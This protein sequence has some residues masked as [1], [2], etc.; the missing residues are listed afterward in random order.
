MEERKFEVR[1][2]NM[3]KNRGLYITL[4]GVLIVSALAGCGKKDGL[5]PENPTRI[6][7]LTYYNG[8]PQIAFEEQVKLFNETVGAEKGIFVEA[9]SSGDL[10][11]LLNTLDFELS[12]PESERELAD[13]FCC[14]A[15][16]AIDFL[17][18]DQLVD[19]DEYFTEDE[20]AE[21]VDAYIEEGRIGKNDELFLFPM[22]K[23]TEV[24]SV[25]KTDWDL[26]A[27][28]T[29][30]T[31]ESLSTWEGLAETAK[32]YYEWTDAATQEPND[33]K[34]FFGRDAMA[35]YILCGMHQQDADIFQVSDGSTEITV[36]REAMRKVWDNYYVPYISGYY[37][38]YGRY[39]SDDMKTGDI[40]ALVGSS[41]GATFL[42]S[43]VTIG[44]E[45]PYAIEIET[46]EIPNFDGEDPVAVQQGAGMVVSKSDALR[47]EASVTFLKW[48]TDS[49]VNTEFAVASSYLPVKKDANNLDFANQ[50]NESK[51][52]ETNEEIQ[53]TL[54]AS[55]EVCQ[56]SE[57]YTMPS[58]TG[59][60]EC[61]DILGNS[62]QEKMQEDRAGIK[63]LL[64]AGEVTLEEAVAQFNTDENFE[65]WCAELETV[66][67]DTA[68]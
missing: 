22:A 61:R 58:F 39:R 12:K 11:E 56:N 33:G 55:F 44:D 54:K 32:Q 65:T 47:Q 1:R 63:E 67:K 30:C 7:V 62:F 28:A 49:E 59:S 13:I 19:L 29:G 27:A 57:L 42:P 26:F 36:E 35:N 14:Y 48:F 46:T 38:S 9:T 60:N 40:I 23:S 66:L 25:N 43:E 41:S 10:S 15:S 16:T 5:D 64:S 18:E 45:E 51:G 50:I 24:M 21:Y 37:G 68:K 17:Q 3:K 2:E 52:F 31:L 34:A 6:E 8:A 53:G 20:L 4:G